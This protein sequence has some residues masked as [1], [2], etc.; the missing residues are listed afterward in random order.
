MTVYLQQLVFFILGKGRDFLLILLFISGWRLC[1]DVVFKY[2][3][4]FL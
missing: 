4:G 3:V 2:L 1:G